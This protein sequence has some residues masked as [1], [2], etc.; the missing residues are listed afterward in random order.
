MDAEPSR[1]RRRRGYSRE[2]MAQI[3]AECELSGVS[4]AKVALAHGISANIVHGW[5]KLARCA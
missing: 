3:L 1:K 2:L 5:R 4:V